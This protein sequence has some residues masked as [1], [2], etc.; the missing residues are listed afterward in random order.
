MPVIA[1]RFY[2]GIEKALPIWGSVSNGRVQSLPALVNFSRLTR[3]VSP[4][5]SEIHAGLT[6]SLRK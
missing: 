4:V 1:I 6:P 2:R 3:G 5:F